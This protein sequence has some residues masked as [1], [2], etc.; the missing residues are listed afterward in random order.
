VSEEDDFR[1][2][3]IVTMRKTAGKDNPFEV[4]K[5][6]S[7]VVGLK[8]VVRGLVVR[9]SSQVRNTEIGIDGWI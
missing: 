9:G 3:E 7:S 8:T 5:I 2:R 1:E 4:R 6:S